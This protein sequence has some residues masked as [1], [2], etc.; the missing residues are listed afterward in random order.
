MSDTE[1]MDLGPSPNKPGH[2]LEVI[3]LGAKDFINHGLKVN[4]AFDLLHC[5]L[6]HQT[7]RTSSNVLAVLL[8]GFN[9]L[10]NT[11]MQ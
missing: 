4:G 3:N 1:L 2:L 7:C 8:L 11:T 6:D 10:T 9:L 5:I